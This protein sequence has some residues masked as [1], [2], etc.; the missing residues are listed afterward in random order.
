MFGKIE[1]GTVNL[2]DRLSLM[3]S[4]LPCQVQ[5]LYNSKGEP[6][7]YAKP[8]ENI[9]IRLLQINDENQVNKGDVLCL[10]DQ[11]MPVSDLFEAE[12]EVLELLSYKPILSKGY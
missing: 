9:Q 10:R 1:S 3:P 6:V 4:N 2:G 11:L 8:G 12:I 5:S 7:R